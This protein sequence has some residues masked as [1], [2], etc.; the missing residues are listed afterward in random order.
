MRDLYATFSRRIYAFA[1][2]QLRNPDD[3]E[4]VVIDTMYEVW[5]R[6]RGFKGSSKFSTWLLGVARHKILD[7]LRARK[8]DHLDIEGEGLADTLASDLPGAFDLLAERQRRESVIACMEK[9]P[10]PQRECLHLVF[11]EGLSLA[12]I[13][14]IQTCPE[15]TVKTRLFHARLRIRD[16]LQALLA[17][18]DGRG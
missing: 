7:V 6:P 12:E 2:N 15:N 13:A 5:R 10:S 11:Y 3:A 16:C 4:D 1:L 17:R 9:L 18:E 8:L 14:H